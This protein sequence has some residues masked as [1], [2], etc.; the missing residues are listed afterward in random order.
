MKH[1]KSFNESNMDIVIDKGKVLLNGR[2]IGI[3]ASWGVRPK[4]DELP[5]MKFHTYYL[6]YP[7]EGN[8]EGLIEEIDFYTSYGN[9]EYDIAKAIADEGY[10]PGFKL[11]S[12]EDHEFHWANRN[13]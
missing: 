10:E 7:E 8:D 2:L 5:G 1:I 3:D 9:Y 6:I 11:M 12:R 13:Y 4:G